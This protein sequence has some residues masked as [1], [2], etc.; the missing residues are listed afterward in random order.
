MLDIIIT[1]TGT[2]ASIKLDA[3]FTTVDISEITSITG[4]A[5]VQVAHST[6]AMPSEEESSLESEFL[7]EDK[8]EH[9]SK[10][11][12][13]EITAFN[14]PALF[15]PASFTISF[16]TSPN[17]ICESSL[18]SMPFIPIFSRLCFTSSDRLSYKAEVS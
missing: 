18:L 15:S 6:A 8:S 9:I 7:Y 13:S 12:V 4:S 2:N 16:T 5:A 3:V 17:E 14:G 10:S 11:A 1:I